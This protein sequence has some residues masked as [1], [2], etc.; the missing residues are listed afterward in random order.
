MPAAAVDLAV[1]ARLAA[2]WSTTTINLYNIDGDTPPDGSPFVQVDYPVVNEEQI[3][4]GAPGNNV[5]REDGAIR[6]RLAYPRGS[7]IR[8]AY[9][10]VDTLRGLLRAAQFSG[11][12]TWAAGGPALDDSADNGNYVILSFIVPYYYDLTG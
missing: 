3:T 9:Q 10:W 6:V 5:F 7:G 12:N 4:I 8:E 11:V 2:G 1:N